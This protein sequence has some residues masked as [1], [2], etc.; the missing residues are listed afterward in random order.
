MTK[1]L[2]LLRSLDLYRDSSGEQ[3]TW[4]PE[5]FVRGPHGGG[6]GD[7]GSSCALTPGGARTF[8]LAVAAA[9][10][11]TCGLT[12]RLER[13][14]EQGDPGP[15][16]RWRAEF[17]GASSPRLAHRPRRREAGGR[18]ASP[19]APRAVSPPAG[20]RPAVPV[21]LEENGGGREQPQHWRA[22]GPRVP[23]S[24]SFP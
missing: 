8:H 23:L 17:R 13:A 4:D 16:I 24:F 2:K 7:Q 22:G 1:N 3:G 11:G 12:E 18:G 6:A 19:A 9:A 20:S 5:R 21:Q 15:P 10:G 14:A